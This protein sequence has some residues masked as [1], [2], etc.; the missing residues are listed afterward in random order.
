MSIV[1]Y[2][3]KKTGVVTVYES[4]SYYDPILKQSRPKRKYL[5]VED[6]V[7]HEI[8]PS[9]GTRG[10]KRIDRGTDEHSEE[11]YRD[12]Y[13]SLLKEQEQ[14]KARIEKLE[15]EKEKLAVIVRD[16]LKAIRSI[17]RT[18]APLCGRETGKAISMSDREQ[19][20][21]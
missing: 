8:I 15:A 4:T 21:L 9:S 1:R 5:G 14:S 12:L 18:V 2:T 19:K 7:T 6:P 3:N 16:L 11:E 20:E 10:R 17:D 13:I